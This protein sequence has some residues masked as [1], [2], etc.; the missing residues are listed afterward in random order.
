MKHI[1]NFRFSS[2]FIF[3]NHVQFV[4]C[5]FIDIQN[6]EMVE[7][8]N[9]DPTRSSQT[10]TNIK[11]CVSNA[12]DASMEKVT[13]ALMVNFSNPEPTCSSS[14]ATIVREET[15]FST[16]NLDSKSH[17]TGTDLTM[18]SDDNTTLNAIIVDEEVREFRNWFYF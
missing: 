12:E 1:F 13:S 16:S 4:R 3:P 17:G 7:Q 2:Y 15:D 14:T 18:V 9:C 11:I 6:A 10:A 8:L 5:N